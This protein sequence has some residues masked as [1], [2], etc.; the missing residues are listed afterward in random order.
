MFRRG[1]ASCP[2]AT[3]T[4]SV[5]GHY[6]SYIR[7]RSL[8]ITDENHQ[9]KEEN[10]LLSSSTGYFCWSIFDELRSA[11]GRV[12]TLSCSLFEGRYL[13]AQ[14]SGPNPTG[15]LFCNAGITV[16][17]RRRRRSRWTQLLPPDCASVLVIVCHLPHSLL[18][19]SLPSACKIIPPSGVNLPLYEGFHS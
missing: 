1:A 13:M 10:L 9:C 14:C 5:D 18:A 17:G 19:P 15:H 12:I 16:G 8:S 4:V 2:A 11:C 3:M 7:L 6:I